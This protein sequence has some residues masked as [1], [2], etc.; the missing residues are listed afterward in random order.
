MELKP[1]FAFKWVRS[2]PVLPAF[3]YGF[4]EHE[5]DQY[6]VNH[7]QILE[8]YVSIKFAE[9]LTACCRT[10]RGRRGHFLD[11]G[12]NFGWFAL[13]AA[14][15]GCDVDTFEPVDWFRHV[16]QSSLKL[17]EFV[18]GKFNVHSLIVSDI[19]GKTLTLHVPSDVDALLG[20]A[21]VDGLNVRNS[22][23]L[24]EKN[25]TTI[26]RMFLPETRSRRSCG[27]KVDVEGLEP[28]VFAGGSRFI[29]EKRPSMIVIELSPGM[30]SIGIEDMLDLFRRSEYKPHQLSWN[31]IKSYDRSEW[32]K[33][34]S[35]Y[36][37]IWNYTQ[38]IQR[39]GFNC[40]L[41]LTR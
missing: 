20:A 36:A 1:D 39:C 37:V 34:L 4:P 31:V 9:H 40:M 19:P 27:L 13:L 11:V 14:A 8:P 16:L 12:G 38:I 7:Q 5:A 18:L 17:N 29:K 33:P 15:S 3:I 24:L 26:D 25:T 21:G 2:N 41:M 32:S 35:D 30:S 23:I 28:R 22:A 10:K 6:Q